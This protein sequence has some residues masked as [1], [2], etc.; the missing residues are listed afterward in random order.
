MLQIF[1]PE[2]GHPTISNVKLYIGYV[3]GNRIIS[4]PDL[5]HAMLNFMNNGKSLPY[6]PC[7]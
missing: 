3:K 5:G 4:L 2:L 7:N 6:S 1:L